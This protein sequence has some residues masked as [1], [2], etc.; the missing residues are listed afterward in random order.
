MLRYALL[1]ACVLAAPHAA[2]AHAFLKRAVPAANSTVAPPPAELRLIFGSKL[3][4]G[5]AKMEVSVDGQKLTGLPDAATDADGKTVSLA[6]PSP[7][8]GAYSVTWSVVAH[9]GHR[10]GGT[11]SFTAKAK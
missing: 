4:A 3:E 8:P 9:D 5:F 1:A 11:Y 2:V 10:T 6:L 7:T